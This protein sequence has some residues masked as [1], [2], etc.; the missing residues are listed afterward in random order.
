MNIKFLNILLCILLF[1]ISDINS[2]DLGVI[3]V[4]AIKNKNIDDKIFS[5]KEQQFSNL[6]IISNEQ[7]LNRQINLQEILETISGVQVKRYGSR[8]DFATISIRGSSS[9]QIAYFIDGI[10]TNNL[11]GGGFNISELPGDA[12]DRI[13]IY[14][15]SAPFTFG[16]QS[17]A[18][19]LNIK[20][21]DILKTK[22][23]L[24][25]SFG[26]FDYKNLQLNYSKIFNKI[27]MLLNIQYISA[28]N[29]FEFLNDNRTQFY[30]DDDFRDTR[31]NNDFQKL[32]FLSKLNYRINETEIVKFILLQRLENKGL[33]GPTYKITE[34]SR[35]KNNDLTLQTCYS[36][37]NI[38]GLTAD[39]EGAIFSKFTTDKFFDPKA[40]LG[41][42]QRDTND[43][44][45][46]IGGKL[47]FSILPINYWKTNL[48]INIHKVKFKPTDKFDNQL[49]LDQKRVEKKLAFENN[50]F[51]LNDKLILTPGLLFE[52]IDNS[53]M[54]Q[55][56]PIIA[57]PQYF[58][59]ET[60]IS[61]QLG[62]N[63]KLTQDFTIK[64]TIGEYYR[65]PN[66]YELFGDYGFITGNVSLK[67]ERSNNFD[68]GILY[69]YKYN[70]WQMFF[71]LSIYQRK[72]KDM[73]QWLA[74]TTQIIYPDN[75][76]SAEIKGIE[77]NLTLK[78]KFLYYT[79]SI[80][81]M[82]TLNKSAVVNGLNKELPAKPKFDFSNEL[83]FDSINL[84]LKIFANFNYTG[85]SFAD[86]DNRYKNADK[87]NIN[88][89]VVYYKNKLSAALELKNITD[90]LNQDVYGF[91]LPGRAYY[92]KLNY[93]F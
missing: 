71:D 41:L 65:A 27:S 55:R 32:Y 62:F 93:N 35:L 48:N 21:L 38:F 90:E 47:D 44:T 66:I 26:S 67:P 92:S 42:L 16:G 59:N 17:L 2:Y 58:S 86:L 22:S 25:Y 89:G 19:V 80:T 18:G 53:V 51:L 61:K 50:F 33:T 39:F 5:I 20:T 88:L 3:T 31:K 40:E 28:K 85:E 4:S 34:N 79:N 78:Y 54:P 73:I 43:K 24:S 23:N 13:E 74:Y 8:D 70:D 29:N 81:Y 12:I 46:D 36:K 68:I 87:K 57:K 76:G 77:N 72:V 10:Q 9:E 82:K 69:K 49:Y 14:K 1:S 37:K 60:L 56:K 45:Q 7:F 63:Y 83:G 75:I 52:K 15:S 30:R 64:S 91:P 6:D 84:G 11:L